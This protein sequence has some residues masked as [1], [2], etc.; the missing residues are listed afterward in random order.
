MCHHREKQGIISFC[1]AVHTAYFIALITTGTSR[2]A[3]HTGGGFSASAGA[4]DLWAA[5]APLARLLPCEAFSRAAPV[6]VPSSDN[7]C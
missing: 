3:C 5:D 7:D 6:A 1:A 2:F 4:S